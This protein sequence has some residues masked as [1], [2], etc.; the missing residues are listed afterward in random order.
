MGGLG[1]GNNRASVRISNKNTGH[2]SAILECLVE[3]KGSETTNYENHPQ[4]AAKMVISAVK[5]KAIDCRANL[6]DAP[7]MATYHTRPD[8]GMSRQMK[9][10]HNIDNC[11][12]W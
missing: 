6:V 4:K 8:T 2:P 1:R 11:V 3:H 9:D 5:T 7:E 10:P 12:Q